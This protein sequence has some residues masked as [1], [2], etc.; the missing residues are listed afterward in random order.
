[1]RKLR[2]QKYGDRRETR[3]ICKDNPKV[4]ND[5]MEREGRD[6]RDKKSG[7]LQYSKRMFAYAGLRFLKNLKAVYEKR[8]RG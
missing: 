8:Q 1:M 7:T 4:Q 6:G 5:L 3:R 2:K